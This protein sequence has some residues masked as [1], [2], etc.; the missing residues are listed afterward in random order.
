MDKRPYLKA[1]TLT[2]LHELGEENQTVLK[3][4]AQLEMAGLSEAQQE[5]VL[6]DLSAA[7]L[8]LHEHTRGLD[9]LIDELE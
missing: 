9:V 6:G 1:S 3:L 5:T 2:L 4:P 7:M 8:H